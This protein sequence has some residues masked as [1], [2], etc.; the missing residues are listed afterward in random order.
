[1]TDDRQPLPLWPA[2]GVPWGPLLAALFVLVATREC[3][4]SADLA[5]PVWLNAVC[6]AGMAVPLAA[7]RRFPVPAVTVAMVAA[8]AQ[9]TWL[10]PSTQLAM[11]L[12]AV[13]VAAFTAGRYV[14]HRVTAAGL[15]V[16]CLAEEWA[17]PIGVNADPLGDAL[18]VNVAVWAA[19]LLGRSALGREQLAREER[20]RSRAEHLREA[21]IRA[22][23]ATERQAVARDLHDTVAHAVTL[24]VLQATGTR[25]I[26][27]DRPEAAATALASI[28]EAGRQA[29]DDLRAMLHVLREEDD[30]SDSADAPQRPGPTLEALDEL[31]RRATD[32]GV[33]ITLDRPADCTHLPR[34][35]STA[36]YRAA[37]EG[38]TNATRHAPGAA[39]HLTVRAAPGHL[40]VVVSNGPSP[41][42]CPPVT[43]GS[44][45]GLV[46][47]RER[48]TALGGTMAATTRHDG[49]FTLTTELPRKT[50]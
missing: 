23:V 31:V 37:Q 26:A 8:M 6:A 14:P 38:L 4:V 25:L 22:A 32:S 45:T 27:R 5:G 17:G 49:G 41:Q 7:G 30:A 29:M 12:L 3:A 46:G 28:E 13:L 16:L 44:G 9:T 33:D 11:P 19:W 10:T 2:R 21:Q 42:E 36:A 35:L 24:M 43:V 1:M 47:L 40:T 15:L 50:P 39:V 20:A 34:T 18:F 48:V